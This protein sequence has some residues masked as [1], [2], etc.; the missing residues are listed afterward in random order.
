MSA[1]VQV[2]MILMKEWPGMVQ[3]LQL[4]SEP[5]SGNWSLVKTL[6]GVSLDRVTV[7]AHSRHM[8]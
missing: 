7:S 1:S 5:C 6:D 4:E 2:G 3:L 8:Q